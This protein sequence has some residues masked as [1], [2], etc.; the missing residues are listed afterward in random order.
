MFDVNKIRE[1]FPILKR[2]IN[3]KDLVYLDNAATTQKPKQVLDAVQNYYTEHN[4]NI[5]R[6]VHQ[7]SQEASEMYDDAHK[8]VGKFLNAKN[9][10]LETIFVRN[11]TEAMNLVAYGWAMHELKPGDEIVSTVMEHHANIVPWQFL[12]E[13]GI[14]V[15]F[16]DINDDGTLNMED[17][18]KKITKKT[19]LVTCVHASNVVGTINDVKEIGKIAHDNDALFLADCAQSVPHMPVD[20]RKINCDF[21]AFSGHKML[22]PM[23]SGALYAKKDILEKMHPFLGGGDMIREVK[24]EK[25]TW[26]DLP[27]KFEAGTPN[28]GGGVGL[29]AAVDYLNKLGI[30]NVRKH[31]KDILSYGLDKFSEMKNID[32]Y[33]PKNPDIRGG[34]ITFNMKGIHPHDVA[35]ILDS[36]YGVAIR[37]G[38]HCA[39]PLTERLGQNSTCRASFYIYNKKEEIDVLMEGLKKVEQIFGK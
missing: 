8:K 29:G 5:H 2:K 31:E 23:G 21:L 19:K 39:Q 17:L 15:N 11:A 37:S 30:D 38:H 22:A 20:V 16:A 14:V 3:G 12:R 9:P 1:D 26:N 27:W 32:I 7:L 6:G 35:G 10:E 18:K 28:V 34:L 4:A 36:E 13:Q 33:G 25:T 24:L